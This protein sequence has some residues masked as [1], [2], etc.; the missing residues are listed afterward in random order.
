[1]KTLKLTTFI[2]M[3]LFMLSCS[4]D[5]E[6]MP[7]A[8]VEST[9]ISNLHAPQEGGQ[10][11]PVSGTF[12][13]FDFE[14]GQETNSDTDWDI[15]FRGTTIAVNGGTETGTTDEPLRTSDAGVTIV[16]GTFEDITEVT[17]DIEFDQDGQDGFA[18]PT[19]SGNGWY[20]YDFA[21]NILS[22][23]PGKIIVVK[24]SDGKYAK[25]EILSY[26]EDAPSDIDPFEDA[27]R[28]YTFR[29]AYNPNDGQTTFN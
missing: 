3:S 14:T 4:D 6:V 25:I 19:G 20:N 15:A 11:Q 21:T 27:P 26:Y 24:T 7:L 2:L 8:E 23:I 10:G 9:T 17:E 5:D 22:P 16:N 28:Y 12:T 13:K 18:I 1:M 29:Y